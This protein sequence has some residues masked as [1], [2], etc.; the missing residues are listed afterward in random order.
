[1]RG[2]IERKITQLEHKVYMM[3]QR[4]EQLVHEAY[5]KRNREHDD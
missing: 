5:T 3:K 2:K 1:M 4:I